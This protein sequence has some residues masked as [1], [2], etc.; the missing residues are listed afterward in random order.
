MARATEARRVA[1]SLLSERRRR[2]ARARD[3]LRASEALSG[4]S[5]RDRALATRLV[6]GATAAQGELDRVIGAHLRRGAK[7]EPRVRDALRLA[8]FELLYLS[9][10]VATCVS[11]GVELVRGVAPR[12][13]G[14]AN[15]VLRRVS[16]EDARALAASR[17]RVAAGECDPSD[18]ARIG[19]LPVWLAERAWA[20]LGRERACAWAASALEPAGAYVAANRTRWTEEDAARLLSAAGCAPEPAALPGSFL[21]GSPS[22]LAASGLVERVD[23]LPCDLAAQEVA[24]ACAPAPGSRVLEVGQGRGTKTVLLEGVAVASGGPCQIVSVEV[25]AGKSALAARRMEAA[26]LADHVRCLVADG[27]GLGD[28]LGTFDLVL[29]DAPCSG[30]GTLARHPEIA[31]S[32][33]EESLPGL[34]ALQTSILRAAAGRVRPG[35]LLV[36]ATCS[37]LAEEDERVVDALLAS[38]AG[39]GLELLDARRTALPHADTHF[40]ARLRRR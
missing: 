18:L 21:L 25:D 20:S 5:E 2:S 6:M 3:L 9:T 32:L 10:P 38:P 29:V 4:L 16:S 40:V 11:Q 39:A 36:Y 17:G 19:A 22:R 26:G 31:W 15:A 30:T 23:V 27:Q 13:A 34:A 37:V 7:L 8:A 1:L 24:L 33:R 14:L 35:G 28:E 12:A